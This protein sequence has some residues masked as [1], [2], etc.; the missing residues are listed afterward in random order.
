[1]SYKQ[2]KATAN[3]KER[4]DA[5]SLVER[6]LSSIT[7]AGYKTLYSF[8]D[9]LLNVRDQ[10]ILS[11]VLKML[12]KRDDAILN[13]IHAHQPELVAQLAVGLTG[14]VRAKEGQW[15]TDYLWLGE[16][17]STFELLLMFSLEKIM[18]KAREIAPNLCK[19]LH[20][21]TTNTKP[22]VNGKV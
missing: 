22:S 18:S 14:E 15:L 11:C 8:V 16:N 2:D 10:Q 21:V 3:L 1:M 4:A 13:N 7:A 19:M 5:K 6:M 9:E 17:Q 20:Q 12:G